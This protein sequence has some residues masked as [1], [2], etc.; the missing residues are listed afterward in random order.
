MHGI[1]VTIKILRVSQIVV[2]YSHCIVTL[3]IYE[4]T[5]YG[6]QCKILKL[7]QL[8]TKHSNKNV[9]FT[10]PT[11]TIFSAT[12]RTYYNIIMLQ[13]RTPLVLKNSGTI[14][15]NCSNIATVLQCPLESKYPLFCSCRLNI[16]VC[17][18]HLV[19]TC[20]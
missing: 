9:V 1:L 15:T 3:V 16:C 6:I 14:V 17:G 12:I 11:E 5:T 7:R 2:R 19:A 13:R 10:K 4:R 20:L 8:P 18:P